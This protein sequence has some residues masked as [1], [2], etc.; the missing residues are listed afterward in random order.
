MGLFPTLVV[1]LLLLLLLS[2][3][4]HW[5]FIAGSFVAAHR[6]LF[7]AA[8][9]LLVAVACLVAEHRLQWLQLVSSVVVARGLS[10]LHGI[11]N[12]LGPGIRPRPLH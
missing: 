3:L 12:L 2:L 10:L 6:L 11:R 4:L 7:V 5:V 9:E 1:L 8:H